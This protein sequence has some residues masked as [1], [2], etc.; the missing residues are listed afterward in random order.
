MFNIQHTYL[1]YLS[2]LKKIDKKDI[3]FYISYTLRKI[4]KLDIEGRKLFPTVFRR[5]KVTY[6]RYRGSLIDLFIQFGE[7][8]KG[9][10]G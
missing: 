10:E 4:D 9:K 8:K 3:M 1:S 6:N 5:N 2:H 7:K